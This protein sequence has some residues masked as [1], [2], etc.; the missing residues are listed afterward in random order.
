MRSIPYHLP[1]GLTP[2]P[3]LP[4]GI[5]RQHVPAAN[6]CLPDLHRLQARNTLR[7]ALRL[8]VAVPQCAACVPA[9]CHVQRQ[10]AAG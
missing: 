4:R 7:L 3:A 2:R 8:A 1:S 9:L 6:G 5:Q 10:Q